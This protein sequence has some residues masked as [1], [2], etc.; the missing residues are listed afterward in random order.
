MNCVWRIVSLPAIG[1][2]SVL[3]AAQNLV[4]QL[5]AL[6]AVLAEQRLDV[7]EGGRLQRFEP[8]VLVYVAHDADDVL[9]PADVGR[10]KIARPASRLDV[11]CSQDGKRRSGLR[12]AGCRR[13]P[14]R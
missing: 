7:L 6:L 11:I 10:Q 14:H 1:L 13:P 3:A 4:N 5:V 12:T 2:V 8:V 9:A